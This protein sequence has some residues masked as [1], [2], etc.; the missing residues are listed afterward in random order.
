MMI[1]YSS[2]PIFAGK[3]FIQRIQMLVDDFNTHK[4]A[5]H[6]VAL[7]A[8]LTQLSESNVIYD[9]V[10]VFTQQ[11]N[12]YNT[13]DTYC[14]LPLLQL[15]LSIKQLPIT[16]L[17]Y[18]DHIILNDIYDEQ[19]IADVFLLSLHKIQTDTDR[20]KHQKIR[21]NITGGTKIMA[22]ILLHNIKQVFGDT[23]PIALCYALR[24]KQTNTT[25][26]KVLDNA[27]V[28]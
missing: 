11:D 9:L 22:L 2:E 5:V 23:S 12:A 18:D 1:E 3:S 21:R 24:N 13:T 10:G 4:N 20:A 16:L 7:D 25:I 17:W 8:F 26:F 15:Y 6:F 27:L 14:I 19:R 28:L